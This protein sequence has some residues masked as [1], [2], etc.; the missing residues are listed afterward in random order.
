MDKKQIKELIN[1]VKKSIKDADKLAHQDVNGAFQAYRQCAEWLQHAADDSE[2]VSLYQEVV[3][4]MQ[5]LVNQSQQQQAPAQQA[6]PQQAYAAPAS[7]ELTREQKYNLNAQTQYA[8]QQHV[9][10]Q[11]PSSVQPPPRQ[12]GGWTPLVFTHG[13]ELEVQLVRTD[14]SFLS[15]DEMVHLMGELVKEAYNKFKQ[16]MDAGQVP[17]FIVQK[18][19]GYP[20]LHEDHEKG[21]IMQV[22]SLLPSGQRINIDSFGRDGN[23]AAIT[24]ILELVTPVCQYVEEL[25]WW[26]STLFSLAHQVLAQQKSD[27]FIVGS[28]LNGTVEYMRGLSFGDHSHIGTFQSPLEKIQY[29]DM[30]RNFIPAIIALSVNSPIVKNKPT[31]EIKIV[32]GRYAAP[33]CVR[34]IRLLNNTT[35]LSGLNNPSKYPPYLLDDNEQTRQQFLTTVGKADFYDAR[36]QDVYPYTDFGTIEVRVCDAQISVSRRIGICLLLQ[37]L[38]YKTRK[39]LAAGRYVPGASSECIVKNRDRAVRQ[40]LFGVF[41][42]EGIDEAQ[43]RAYD[44]EFANMYLG[45]GQTKPRYLF[46]HV[47]RMFRWLAPELRE[48]GY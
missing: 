34:S 30:L 43:F 10:A 19:G 39:L 36:F 20:I 40:G 41:T 35:M 26:E 38:G 27:L 16:W 15:G 28:G 13:Q 31:D 3:A 18:M 23:V 17:Q 33:N 21:L 44:P 42:T 25:A 1:S 6:S 45:D 8:A 22:P 47:D 12:A 5:Q 46:E 4:K 2:A 37:A 29:Y 48:L 24:Y 9:Q 7:G 32:K 11:K 14:G